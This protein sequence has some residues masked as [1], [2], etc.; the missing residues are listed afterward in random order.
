MI[1]HMPSNTI[2]CANA[3]PQV[4]YVS[5]PCVCEHHMCKY[6]VLTIYNEQHKPYYLKREIIHT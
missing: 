2:Q 3:C 5:K 6:F 1:W 4:L